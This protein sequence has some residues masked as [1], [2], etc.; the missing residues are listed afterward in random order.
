MKVAYVWTGVV[1][2]ALGHGFLWT[3]LVN[4]LHGLSGPR[5]L[6]KSITIA[7]VVAFAVLP[8]ALMRRYGSSLGASAFNPFGH[9]DVAGWYLRLCALVGGASLIVKPWI[10]SQRYDRRVLQRWTQQY[11]PATEALGP[12]LLAGGVARALGRIPGNEALKLSIDRKRLALPAL[13]AKLDGLTI[14]HL[15]DLHMT[16]R[17][18]RGFY[19][20]LTRQVNELRPDVIAVTG[21]IVEHES[22]WPWLAET[23]GRLCAPMGVYFVLGNHDVLIDENRTRELLVEAGLVYVGGRCLRCDWNGAA[24]TVIGNELPWLRPAEPVQPPAKAGGEFRLALCHTPDQFGFGV[25]ASA[26]LVL[27]GHTHGGQVQAP[28]LGVIA[29][30]SLHGTR[31][32][33]GVFRRRTTVMHVSRGISSETPLRWR[34]P[35]ELALL[36]L[37]P[38]GAGASPVGRRP[39]GA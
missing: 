19:E 13:P 33:C 5:W 17:V 16:G 38:G 20:C 28:L 9:G 24:V 31:Y 11:S 34:S 18:G 36:E 1:L 39:G 21:D 15:S 35:P 22:C 32:A 23:L 12:S 30:P 6:I 26:D 2:A 14:V 37:T 29:S 10:E 4:R 7:L 3:G 27:A 8:L 25:R